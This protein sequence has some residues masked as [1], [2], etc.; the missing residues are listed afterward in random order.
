MPHPLYLR[1]SVTDRC[2]LACR[3]CRPEAAPALAGPSPAS[4]EELLALV[5]AIEGQCGLRKVRL[6]GGEPLMHPDPPR[7]VARLHAR[8]P[9]A[10][11][12]L[13]TNAIRLRRYAKALLAAGL[14]SLNI[15]LDTPDAAT[16]AHLTRGGRLAEA[17]DG[18]AAAREAGFRALR[19]NTVLLRTVNGHQ[20]A[21]LARLAAGLGCEL[22]F[23]ELMPTGEGAPRFAADF[24]PADEALARL[25]EQFDYVGPL[26]DSDT[27]RRHRFLV[28]GCSQPLDVGFIAPVT[29]PFCG[30]CDRLRLDCRGRLYCCLRTEEGIDLLGPWRDGQPDEVCRRIRGAVEHKSPQRQTWPTR[31][32]ASLGG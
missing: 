20:L 24:L 28:R 13:T 1:L 27:A 30:T 4:E 6:T 19:L 16:Y 26:P 12:A 5:A 2:N 8:L 21:D 10:D 11:L 32:M 14:T 31:C 23:I 18:I 25:T 17:L 22:R 7:L 3:Y 9:R 29:Q 15:S